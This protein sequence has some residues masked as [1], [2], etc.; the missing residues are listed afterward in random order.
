MIGDRLTLED[1]KELEREFSAAADK[2]EDALVFARGTSPAY[3]AAD[4]AARAVYGAVDELRKELQ[5]QEAEMEGLV[6][7]VGTEAQENASGN[8]TAGRICQDPSRDV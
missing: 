5:E 8:E 1:L 4:R 6:E 2:L 3:R 7:T